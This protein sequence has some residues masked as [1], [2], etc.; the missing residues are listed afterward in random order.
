[1]VELSIS[2]LLS[3]KYY[4]LYM[5]VRMYVLYWYSQVVNSSV[6]SHTNFPSI[7]NALKT[8]VSGFLVLFAHCTLQPFT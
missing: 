8:A 2:K 6:C 4:F 7:L 5:Y 1:M 3:S